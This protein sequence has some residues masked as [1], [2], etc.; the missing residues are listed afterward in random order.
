MS[1]SGPEA[2]T[3]TAT[4]FISGLVLDRELSPR[5]RLGSNHV[6]QLAEALRAGATLPPIVVERETSRVVDGFHR[7]EAHRR[8]WGRE[9]LVEAIE[10]DYTDEAELFEDAVRLNSAHGSRL[11][12]YDQVRC[13]AIAQTLSIDPDRL[14]AALS[15]RPSYVGDL[16]ARR[17]GTD[18]TT[19]AAIPLKRTIEHMRG[20]DLTPDQIEANAKLGGQD[21]AFYVGQLNLLA[22][23]DLFD[24]ENERVREGL[25]RL[26]SNLE[27]LD[28]SESGG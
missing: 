7:V 28:F 3:S 14:A 17:T 12:P 20:R 11:A 6:R 26:E 22:E 24:L 27:R 9:A 21:Q 19:R 13:A 16:T 1:S 15:V 23:N 4:R 18:L 10:R 8:V 25:R 5:A 2:G